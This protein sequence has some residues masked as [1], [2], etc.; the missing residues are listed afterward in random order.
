MYVC[1]FR[2]MDVCVRLCEIVCNR[3]HMYMQQQ[4]QTEIPTTTAIGTVYKRK[5]KKKENNNNKNSYYNIIDI[6][7]T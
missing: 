7:S 3:T 1:V 5:S 2:Y 6:Y 4:Q